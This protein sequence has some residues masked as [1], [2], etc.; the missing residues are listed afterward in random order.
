MPTQTRLR[1]RA[2]GERQPDDEPRVARVGLHLDPAAVPGDLD[3][4]G[5]V[6]AQAGALSMWEYCRAAST[7]VEMR[8]TES[9]I[10]ASNSSVSTVYASQRSPPSSTSELA[11][12]MILSRKSVVV[13]PAAKIGA[14]SHDPL[15]PWPSSQS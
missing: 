10:S 5:Y 4:V 13:P 9:V 6:D 12:V 8:V 15:M 14:S 7:S 1:R 3:S 11:P 2:L